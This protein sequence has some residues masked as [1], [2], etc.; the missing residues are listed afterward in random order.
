M[1]KYLSILLAILF[2]AV[3]T[4]CGDA[5]DDSGDSQI[6][7]SEEYVSE[8]FTGTVITMAGQRFSPETMAQVQSFNAT[9]E[10][11]RIEA[12]RFDEDDTTRL[13]TEI[14]AGAGPDILYGYLVS[15]NMIEAM[16]ARNMLVDLWTLL[17]ADPELN[18]EDFF[19]NVLEAR[20]SADGSLPVVSNRFVVNTIVGM[21]EAVSH[22][23]TWTVADLFTVVQD[24]FE[25][26]V[27]L[28][29]GW[30]TTA[31]FM[32]HFILF[33]TGT[34]LIDLEAGVSNLESQRFYDL[35]GL[36]AILPRNWEETDIDFNVNEFELLRTG[37]Q[38]LQVHPFF[39]PHSYE[40]YVSLVEDFTIL[41]MPHVDGGIHVANLW[42]LMGI[43]INSE[44]PDVVW[45]FIRRFL[46]P[47]VRIT[48]AIPM[49]IDLYDEMT[50]DAMQVW[51]T[52][53]TADGEEVALHWN[54]ASGLPL[55]GPRR[56]L[57]QEHADAHRALVE[58]VTHVPRIDERIWDIILEELQPFFAEQ[59]TVEEAARIMQNR[60]QT[61][62][63]ER[64]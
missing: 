3:F 50:E 48:H 62:L 43:N 64:G 59:R 15:C 18:R 45:S 46:A 44:H 52:D 28:P 41:G 49:R 22:L 29:L 47:N 38:V 14:M 26:G 36:L 61:L 34:E 16:I 35:L 57:T 60:V 13:L 55:N 2:A 4:A 6:A 10:H 1:K 25:A 33:H 19:Q 32:L 21:P 7:D 51:Q 23:D 56:A 53:V 58:S 31:E 11:Y 37:G 54:T 63:N 5:S 39:G 27:T 24:A 9:N 42:S 20:Q 8:E 12:I 17:D 40:D 30:H